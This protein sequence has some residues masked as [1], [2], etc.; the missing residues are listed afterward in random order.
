MN[1]GSWRWDALARRAEEIAGDLA[2]WPRY[3]RF[4]AREL[5]LAFEAGG[6][7]G[8]RVGCAV[9][10]GCGI[11]FGAGL[12]ACIAERVVAL[13]LPE[14]DAA[15]HA[16]G[17]VRAQRLR[18]R[19]SLRHDLIAADAARLPLADGAADL[20]LSAYVLEHVAERELA[21]R[22]IA[23]VLS[24]DGEALLFLPGAAER[25]W[26]PIWYY[27]HTAR[28]I[29]RSFRAYCRNVG[30]TTLPDGPAA[31]SRSTL[32]AL[33]ASESRFGR[34]SHL[35]GRFRHHYPRFPAVP[36]HGVYR[37]WWHELTS[38]RAAAWR[39][40]LQGAG[41][42][43]IEHRATM[44]VPVALLEE[45]DPALRE[46]AASALSGPIR[47]WGR[48]RAMRALAHGSLWR[49]RRSERRRQ[50]LGTSPH[51]SPTFW[52][53]GASPHRQLFSSA[54]SEQQQPRRTRLKSHQFLPRSVSSYRLESTYV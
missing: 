15:T 20:V 29:F 23:R 40:T 33:D 51:F 43:I 8:E 5:A 12:L 25:I 30:E 4:R 17:L 45:A 28:E 24:D 27:L 2:P 49:V 11:G 52:C 54:M 14:A 46:A 47:R 19:L 16:L 44:L 48:T 42:D 36:P 50:Q 34:I 37:G 32:P 3:Y 22:E 39:S 7:S 18:D 21:C 10:V 35:L 53:G 41:L 26:A 9:E 13:D 38:C 6:G 31:P 1:L